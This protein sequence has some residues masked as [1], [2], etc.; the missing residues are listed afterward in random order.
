MGRTSG[1]AECPD[2]CPA[3][4]V[5]KSRDSTGLSGRRQTELRLARKA[6]WCP[7]ISR[8]ETAGN[9]RTAPWSS[10]W[11][12]CSCRESPDGNLHHVVQQF[13]KVF[14]QSEPLVADD[15]GRAS[16]E[17]IGV[18]AARLGR[19]LKP[20]ETI[21][22]L[23]QHAENRGQRAMDFDGHRFGTIA[24][25]LADNFPM[26]AANHPLDGRAAGDAHDVRKVDVASQRSTGHDQ[27]TRP[28]EGRRG[29]VPEMNEP[30]HGRPTK[31]RAAA[32]RRGNVQREE[33]PAMRPAMTPHG[34]SPISNR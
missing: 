26:P 23:T 5:R 13:Q 8:A 16:L 20:D 19:L 12:H 9:T 18:Q 4:G 25:D 34:Q 22:G 3:N 15:Q 28:V 1:E 32:T 21:A 30:W 27:L 14:G 2:N 24:G 31:K 17:G 29:F 33:S 7:N 6:G 10:P 11:R